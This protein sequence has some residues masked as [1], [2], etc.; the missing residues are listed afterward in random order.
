MDFDKTMLK[1]NRLERELT[2]INRKIKKN[3]NQ[4][5]CNFRFC[6]LPATYKLITGISKYPN[7]TETPICNECLKYINELN[8]HQLDVI[9]FVDIYKL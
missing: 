7:Y 4:I 5:I 3:H 1:I 9:E 2:A 6:D 8:D